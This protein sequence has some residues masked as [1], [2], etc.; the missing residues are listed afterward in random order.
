MIKNNKK[1]LLNSVNLKKIY[2]KRFYHIGIN[3]ERALYFL[4]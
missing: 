4:D 2:T 3:G 1:M